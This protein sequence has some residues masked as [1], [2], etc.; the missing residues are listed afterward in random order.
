MLAVAL[1]AC[2]CVTTSTQTGLPAGDSTLWIDAR[3][4]D[5][6][7]ISPAHTTVYINGMLVGNTNDNGDLELKLAPGTYT[8]RIEARGHEPWQQTITLVAGGQRQ[9]VVPYMKPVAK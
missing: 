1:A 4:E 9:N 5:G 3:E 8:V 7:Q 6:S 2:S